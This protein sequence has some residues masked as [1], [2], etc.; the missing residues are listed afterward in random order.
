M[1]LGEK[2]GVTLVPMIGDF[3][4]FA[5]SV[6]TKASAVAVSRARTTA[7]DRTR[8]TDG[9]CTYGRP[10]GPGVSYSVAGARYL[11]RAA[12]TMR[13]ARTRPVMPAEISMISVA[14]GTS[15]S[16]M[17]DSTSTIAKL[18]RSARSGTRIE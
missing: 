13:V 2:M 17:P 15:S 18:I 7:V 4:S 11:V 10:F 12:L 5:L 6:I 14:A 3:S 9:D 16:L 8:A 1:P